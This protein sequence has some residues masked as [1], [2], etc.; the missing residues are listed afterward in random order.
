[1][2]KPLVRSKNLLDDLRSGEQS[3]FDP[4][5]DQAQKFQEIIDLS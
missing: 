3:I 1:M 5:L 2:H 4:S